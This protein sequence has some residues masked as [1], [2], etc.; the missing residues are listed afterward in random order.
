MRAVTANNEVL[1]VPND[2]SYSL[3]KTLGEAQTAVH[4]DWQLFREKLGNS[5]LISTG[6]HVEF[7]ACT[8][9]TC[10]C[11]SMQKKGSRSDVQNRLVNLKSSVSPKDVYTTGWTSHKPSQSPHAQFGTCTAQFVVFNMLV[12]GAQ[13]R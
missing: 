9:S 11:P 3:N 10:S 2:G 12:W 5:I 1:Q 6:E 4:L 8:M 7:A 13:R